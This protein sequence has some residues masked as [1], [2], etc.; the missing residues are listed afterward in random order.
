MT[1][2]RSKLGLAIPGCAKRQ[3]PLPADR[4][5]GPP[6]EADNVTVRLRF[7]RMR[8]SAARDSSAFLMAAV[9]A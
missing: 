9:I 3:I 1:T 6:R 5:L 7:V 2:P 4:E 8:Q